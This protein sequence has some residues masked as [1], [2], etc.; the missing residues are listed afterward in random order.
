MERDSPL[1]GVTYAMRIGAAALVSAWL[2]G[3]AGP[4]PAQAP[5]Q[6]AAVVAPAPGGGVLRPFPP[7][8]GF[9]DCVPYARAVS[10]LDLHGDAWRWWPQANG[11]YARGNVP[12]IGAVLSFTRTKSLT[13][14][15][16]AVVVAI[17]NPRQILVSHANWGSDGDTR[18]V[19]HERQPVIDVSPGNDWSQ[20]RLENTLGTFGRT[21]PANGF[22]YQPPMT[23]RAGG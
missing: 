2:G 3:C 8:S 17:Q 1:R 23:T 16:V 11:R 20:V 15:H 4:K 13:R 22:I 18:G 12:R 10:G 21:Y 7:T 14:G 19:I 9:I 5:P 6:Q